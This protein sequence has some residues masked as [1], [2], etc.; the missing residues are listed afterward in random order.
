[1]YEC[2]IYVYTCMPEVHHITNGCEPPCSSWVLNS[3]ALKEQSVLLNAEPS[4]QPLSLLSYRT[5]DHQPRDSTTH[6]GLGTPPS[7]TN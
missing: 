3:G 7:I 4:L 1:M 5:Q 6:H 2:S